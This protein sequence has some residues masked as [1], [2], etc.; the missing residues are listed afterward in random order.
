M[1]I[2]IS[3]IIMAFG[4]VGC[5][6]MLSFYFFLISYAFLNFF[7]N[8]QYSVLTINIYSCFLFLINLFLLKYFILIQIYIISIIWIR[9]VTKKINKLN[10]VKSKIC[11]IRLKTNKIKM[12][13]IITKDKQNILTFNRKMKKKIKKKIQK[14]MIIKIKSLKKRPYKIK[15]Y[16]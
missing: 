5:N 13:I 12:M 16:K 11:R 15:G 10:K 6:S 4:F 2:A 9:I 1:I 7:I 14:I 8:F 3:E